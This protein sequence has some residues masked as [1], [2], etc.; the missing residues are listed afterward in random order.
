MMTD[1]E[2]D[3]RWRRKLAARKAVT[4]EAYDEFVALA[5][6]LGGPYLPIGEVWEPT[7]P[8]RG[9]LLREVLARYRTKK[10]AAW[11]STEY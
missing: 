2:L 9:S 3:A 4:D 7:T 10:Q 11:A 8:E 5:E 6:M 1:D